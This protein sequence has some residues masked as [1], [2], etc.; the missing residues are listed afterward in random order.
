MFDKNELMIVWKALESAAFRGKDAK[1]IVALFGK[2]DKI[3]TKMVED[4]E[5]AK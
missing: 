5:K 2:I 1:V 3:L 4:E